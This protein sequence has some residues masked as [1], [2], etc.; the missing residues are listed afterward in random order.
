MTLLL[1]LSNP[2]SSLSLSFFPFSHAVGGGGGGGDGELVDGP[3]HM[4][5]PTNPSYRVRVRV[6]SSPT[7]VAQVAVVADAHIN[8]ST[9]QATIDH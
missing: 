1:L 2:I 9:T 5:L 3:H 4:L 7:D 6:E 8:S